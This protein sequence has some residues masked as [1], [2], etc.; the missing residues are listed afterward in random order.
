MGI[1][2]LEAAVEKMETS[3]GLGD[4]VADGKRT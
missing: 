4:Q 2:P 1:E 3:R